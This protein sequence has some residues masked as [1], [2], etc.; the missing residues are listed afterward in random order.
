MIPI[1][2]TK[3]QYTKIQDEVEKNVLEV[4]RSGSYFN[5]F[6]NKNFYAII[7]RRKRTLEKNS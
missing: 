4:L 1:L 2:D 6:I 7:L 5:S 3:R